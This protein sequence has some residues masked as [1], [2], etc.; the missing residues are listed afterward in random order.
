MSGDTPHTSA[1]DAKVCMFGMVGRMFGSATL[2]QNSPRV[3]MKRK[4]EIT[5]TLLPDFA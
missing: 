2:G 5:E 1:T 3:G 4:L